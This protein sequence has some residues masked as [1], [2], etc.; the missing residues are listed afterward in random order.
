[1]NDQS[2]GRSSADIG[3]YAGLFAV[4]TNKVMRQDIRLFGID[5]NYPNGLEFNT[6][7]LLEP[8]IL[9]ELFVSSGL[10]D[11][12]PDE[13][14]NIVSIERSTRDRG[15]INEKYDL[16][17]KNILSKKDADTFTELNKLASER[18]QAIA[19]ANRDRFTLQ[20]NYEQFG[21]SAE[22]AE[23]MLD[24][25][26]K[27]W[28]DYVVGNYR[29]VTDLSLKSM[30][31]VKD[32]DLSIPEHAYYASQQLD[33]VENN[34]NKFTADPRFKR[35]QSKTGRTPIE[36]LNGLAEYRSVFFTPLYSSVLSIDTP[37]S[38][39][40]L[41]ERKLRIEELDKQI[42]SLQ[43]VV[44]DISSMEIGNR[45]G[46]KG[47]ADGDPDIIQI[48]DGTLN[49]IVGLVRKASL[50]E[51]LTSTLRERH[52]L[53]VEKASIEK[54][55]QQISENELLSDQFVATVTKIFHQILGEYADFLEQ[56]EERALDSRIKLFIT[57]TDASIVGSR[58]HP[59]LNQLSLVPVVI[60]VIACLVCV[61]IRR[62]EEDEER[63]F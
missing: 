6:R 62:K 53:V 4:S 11:F 48:G 24:A 19:D 54:Q 20:V 61:L 29:V 45:A 22:A 12:S 34:L 63:F 40:Y 1:M 28:E 30:A 47:N 37:L 35:M 26:P 57:D 38:E 41:S 33:Y 56:A 60:F 13:Y 46:T 15:F 23:I 7:D 21:I 49:D 10:D 25:W 59:K 27:I 2:L 58:V 5:N 43:T 39:F 3:L 36:V 44:D 50:Q 52:G 17:A 42:A 32:A 31:L 55:L 51:F 14:T 9:E 18:N 16:Q 8:D